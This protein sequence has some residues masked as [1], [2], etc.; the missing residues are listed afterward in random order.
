MGLEA[1]GLGAVDTQIEKAAPGIG[2]DRCAV[3][4]DNIPKEEGQGNG[5]DRGLD[6]L[7]GLFR[8]TREV[9]GLRRPMD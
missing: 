7:A 8:A 2:E 4:A 9:P 1:H 3:I 5:H 6:L